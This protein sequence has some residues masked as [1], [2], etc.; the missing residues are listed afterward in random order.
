MSYPIP[1]RVDR[2]AGHR[3]ATTGRLTADDKETMLLDDPEPRNR[4]QRRAT[5]NIKR[6]PK[7]TDA[8]P[9]YDYKK[10]ETLVSP[11][12]EEKV[13][14]EPAEA[15]PSLIEM[16]HT[17]A[18]RG[19]TGET[20]RL[21]LIVAAPDGSRLAVSAMIFE[22]EKTILIGLQ[23]DPLMIETARTFTEG[24]KIA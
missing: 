9:K 3:L 20:R 8:M 10:Y 15:M 2:R 1:R 11:A 14:A 18:S 5:A 6:K 12:L 16:V 22:T 13:G 17:T 21:E 4:R 23:T 7:G 24:R 19:R